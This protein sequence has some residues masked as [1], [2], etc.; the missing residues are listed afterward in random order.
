MAEDRKQAQ[1]TPGIAPGRRESASTQ[2]PLAPAMDRPSSLAVAFQMD[3][4]AGID[5]DA[6]SSFALA[7]EAQRRGHGLYQSK[8]ATV[9]ADGHTATL[10]VRQGEPSTGGTQQTMDLVDPGARAWRTLNGLGDGVHER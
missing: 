4:L 3:D 8:V 5:I 1:E 9:Y 2:D 6:D 7:L 10:R